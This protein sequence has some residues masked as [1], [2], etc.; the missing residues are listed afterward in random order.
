LLIT[1]SKVLCDK[2]E[3]VYGPEN[4]SVLYGIN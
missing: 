3:L 2:C 1:I 4:S